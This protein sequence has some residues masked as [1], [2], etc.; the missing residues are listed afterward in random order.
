VTSCYR[1]LN[2]SWDFQS[3]RGPNLVRVTT[4]INVVIDEVGLDTWRFTGKLS[5]EWREHSEKNEADDGRQIRLRTTEKCEEGNT[6]CLP[7]VQMIS[8]TFTWS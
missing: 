1:S 6:R 7:P 2:L 5:S 4:P 3:S 8:P